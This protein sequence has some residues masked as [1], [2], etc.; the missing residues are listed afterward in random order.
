MKPYFKKN[1]VELHIPKG[2]WDIENF[3]IENI[4]SDLMMKKPLDKTLMDEYKII[5]KSIDAALSGFIRNKKLN[6][7]I[8]IIK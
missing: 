2:A 1:Y 8:D 7:L 3:T 6:Q 5:E 4:Y